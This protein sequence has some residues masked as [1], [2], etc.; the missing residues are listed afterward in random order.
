[1]VFFFCFLNVLLIFRC[2]S[3]LEGVA[4]LPSPC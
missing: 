3:S 4:L 1:L 2:H